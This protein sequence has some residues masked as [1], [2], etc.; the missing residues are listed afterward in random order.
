MT[1]IESIK[2]S[3]K[4]PAG[5]EVTTVK[6]C[7]V[8]GDVKKL[9]SS[10]LLVL[11]VKDTTGSIKV[12]VWDDSVYFKSLSSPCQTGKWFSFAGT[13]KEYNGIRELCIQR[14]GK[15]AP[16]VAPEGVTISASGRSTT[17]AD[18]GDVDEVV[19]LKAGCIVESDLKSFQNSSLR[20]LTVKDGTG[21]I[22][23]KCWSDSAS[24][25]ELNRDSVAGKWFSFPATVKEYNGIRE[26]TVQ[27]NGKVAPVAAP[28]G[29][30]VSSSYRSTT[31]ADLGAVD[32]M[33]LLE[34]A[35][36][37]DSE[38]KKLQ[39]SD[40]LVLTVKDGTG[41]V[42]V[43]C[44]SDAASFDEL[45]ANSTG[46][47]FSIPAKVMAYNDIKELCIQRGSK[48]VP[49]AAPEGVT[50]SA[51][52]RNST[53]AE[54]GGVD[55]MVAVDAVVLVCDTACEEYKEG[56]RKRQMLVGD[57]TGHVVVN[58]WNSTDDM[59]VS[60]GD[61]IRIKRARVGEHPVQHTRQL[62][63]N[64]SNDVLS[65][66]DNPELSGWW[67]AT[68]MKTPLTSL[69]AGQC[70]LTKVKDLPALQ[71][72]SAEKVSVDMA[73]I[74]T[75]TD[76]PLVLS[77][78]ERMSLTLVDETGSVHLTAFDRKVS[79]FASA[80]VGDAVI[81]RNAEI[82]SHKTVSV[83]ANK[84]THVSLRPSAQVADDLKAWYGKSHVPIPV[85]VST[86]AAAKKM[87]DFKP[88]DRVS[89][90]ALIFLDETLGYCAID[91]SVTSPI[92]LRFMLDGEDL[93]V[94]KRKVVMLTGASYK[95][96]SG[97]LM[98][99]K[100]N[101]AEDPAEDVKERLDALTVGR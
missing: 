71:A 16:I 32:D 99:Y 43:K 49:V 51:S 91:E 72:A 66:A 86:D 38:V 34:A 14:N 80:K 87:S 61:I 84:A 96:D 77:N 18:V 8:E 29:V 56:K 2:A 93:G 55:D 79:A 35:C 76:L 54:V 6:A 42:K 9:S 15:A 100:D 5:Y 101:L 41:T 27:R 78:G 85:S 95:A 48:V 65:S 26:L 28:E 97:V 60:S 82:S 90:A 20:V 62:E 31:I 64:W 24:F 17:I 45:S 19:L 23:V 47:W 21:T 88:G 7:I 12:K 40:L 44:W 74:I 46:K 58:M 30:T 22:K 3:P 94:F 10:E 81:L 11:T 98:I 83:V 73:C 50:V 67:E 75:A 4:I 33:V 52:F 1:T 63:V 53:I 39:S 25:D 36:V 57:T 89:C 13:V 59:R 92:P 37:V 69:S 70:P 68:G